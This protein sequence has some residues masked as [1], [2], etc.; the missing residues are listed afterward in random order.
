MKLLGIIPARYN[1]SRLPGKPLLLI[2]GKSMLRRVYVQALKA[3]ALSKVVVATDDERIFRHVD[4]FNGEVTMTSA[5]LTTSTARC[6]EAARILA[7]NYD[8]IIN[9]PSDMP[10]IQPAQIDALAACL[11]EGAEIAT[12]VR[13]IDNKKDYDGSVTVKVIVNQKQEALYFSRSPVPYVRKGIT[14]PILREKNFFKQTDLYAYRAQTLQALAKL[15]VSPLEELESIEQLRW[16][17]AGFRIRVK[18]THFETITV[19]TLEDLEKV[20][21]LRV[22]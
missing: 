14:I 20:K 1:S 6:A 4:G 15:G 8:G 7:T 12:L 10:F 9:I 5:H 21:G 11:E 3:Q 22:A 16:L 19:D 2:D 17:D 18:E 13:R